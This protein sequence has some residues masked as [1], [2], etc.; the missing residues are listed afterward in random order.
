MAG[1]ILSA[2]RRATAQG[3]KQWQTNFSIDA[4]GVTLHRYFR[5]N[6]F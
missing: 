2:T 1:R 4:G 6:L 5:L 3:V